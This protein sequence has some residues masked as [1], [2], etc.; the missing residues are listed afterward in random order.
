[1]IKERIIKALGSILASIPF[2]MLWYLIMHMTRIAMYTG[3]ISIFEAAYGKWMFWTLVFIYIVVLFSVVYLRFFIK[4]EWL[5]K[6]F[7]V[8]I[9]AI[10]MTIVLLIVTNI[11]VVI[12]LKK[13]D[14]FTTEKWLEYPSQRINMFFDLNESYDLDGYTFQNIEELLGQPDEIYFDTD[15]EGK[16]LYTYEYSDR[17]GNAVYVVFESGVFRELYYVE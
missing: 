9:I 15:K 12:G 17:N 10:C 4:K 6:E 14:K 5:K 1:M 13:F 8:Q 2:I 3:A 11:L 16:D 7:T